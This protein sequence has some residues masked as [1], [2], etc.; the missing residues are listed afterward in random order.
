MHQMSTSQTW[1]CFLYGVL[2]TRVA[3]ELSGGE[4]PR[5]STSLHLRSGTEPVSPKI[6]HDAM[7]FLQMEMPKGG[8]QTFKCWGKGE[9]SDFDT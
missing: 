8:L 3:P 1:W 2:R 5:E 9:F 4:V 7:F 6:I